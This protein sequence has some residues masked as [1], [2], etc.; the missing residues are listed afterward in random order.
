MATTV[1][2]VSRA[3]ASKSVHEAEKIEKMKHKIQ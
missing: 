3:L 1:T 2:V